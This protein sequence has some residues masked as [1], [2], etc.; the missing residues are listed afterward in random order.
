MVMIRYGDAPV[1]LDV[2]SIINQYS[3]ETQFEANLTWRTAP[4]SNSQEVG[5]L[6][7]Y[8]DTETSGKEGAPIVM[9]PAG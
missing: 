3:V 1:F 6:A 7:K 2:A 5:G 9:I 8:T 4:I